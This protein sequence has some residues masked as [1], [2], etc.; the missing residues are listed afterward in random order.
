M[1]GKR[2]ESVVPERTAKMS[3]SDV[4][5]IYDQPTAQAYKT[6][7]SGQLA[8]VATATYDL[9]QSISAGVANQFTAI[10]QTIG[11]IIGK[12]TDAIELSLACGCKTQQTLE[13]KINTYLDARL[14]VIE[15]STAIMQAKM[16]KITAALQPKPKKTRIPIADATPTQPGNGTANPIPT[17]AGTV[18]AN[19][20]ATT[21]P[22]LIPGGPEPFPQPPTP[23]ELANLILPQTGAENGLPASALPSS[24]WQPNNPDGFWFSLEPSA[25]S[26][27]A[28]AAA[29]NAGG[30]FSSAGNIYIN[31]NGP[32]TEDE[33]TQI[34]LALG[35]PPNMSQ[36]WDSQQSWTNAVNRYGDT[37]SEQ[38]WNAM[39]LPHPPISG[40]MP[41]L[42][43]TLDQ[44]NQLVDEALAAAKASAVQSNAQETVFQ[45]TPVLS[46]TSAP[47][48]T[49]PGSSATPSDIPSLGDILGGIARGIGIGA[50]GPAAATA[51]VRLPSWCRLIAPVMDAAGYPPE[52][53]PGC[54]SFEAIQRECIRRFNQMVSST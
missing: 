23:T 37:I 52:F 6:A 4:V 8:G 26:R 30:Q 32:A 11:N 47:L 28:V 1:A 42:S 46:P 50:A 51:N 36:V 22:A 40:P 14:S 3:P 44:H 41:A 7:I 2:L 48:D 21:P 19:P 27:G 29:T 34:L 16:D 31:F 13:A 24:F 17:G 53:A 12:I 9:R 49:G 10:G 38:V 18:S 39:G 45:Q 25:I 20:G 15:T 54:A 5:T 35:I 43:R 33:L